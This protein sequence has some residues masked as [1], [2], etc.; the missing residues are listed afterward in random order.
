[1]QREA[2]AY[3]EKAAECGVVLRQNGRAK[4]FSGLRLRPDT[5]MR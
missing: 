4:C 2:A 3:L 5:E 1:V